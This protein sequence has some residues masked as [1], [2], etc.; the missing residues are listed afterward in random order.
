MQNDISFGTSMLLLVI[1][2]LFVASGLIYWNLLTMADNKAKRKD[3]KNKNKNN[4]I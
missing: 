2:G 3:L 1:F 4:A